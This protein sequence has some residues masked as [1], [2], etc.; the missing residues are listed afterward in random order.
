M[1][2]QLKQVRGQQAPREGHLPTGNGHTSAAPPAAARGEAAGGKGPAAA[3]QAFPHGPA[4]EVPAT[5]GHR[6]H[7]ESGTISGSCSL[8][9][10][11]TAQTQNPRTGPA[12]SGDARF[13]RRNL[14]T[15]ASSHGCHSQAPQTHWLGPRDVLPQGWA[16][17]GQSLGP[18]GAPASPKALGKD[19]TLPLPASTGCQESAASLVSKGITSICLRCPCHPP[20]ICLSGCKFPSSPKDTSHWT[21]TLHNPEWPHFSF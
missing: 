21:R 6:S 13:H 8:Q 1:L 15:A 19:P 10:L 5:A 3:M 9:C 20:Y 17:E 12:V 16:P 2:V 11:C 14:R 4:S 18:G 7:S